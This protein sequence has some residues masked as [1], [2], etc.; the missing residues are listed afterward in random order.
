MNEKVAEDDCH[1]C[2]P[3][4]GTPARRTGPHTTKQ[5]QAAESKEHHG[6]TTK[7]WNDREGISL[8]GRGTPDR[9]VPARLV[10]AAHS[11]WDETRRCDDV[12]YFL[13]D[14]D[15][16]AHG[17]AFLLAHH[18]SRRAGKLASSLAAVDIGSGA[19][20]ALCPR[21]C[22]YDDRLDLCVR[23]WLVD[24]AVL[25]DPSTD[26]ADRRLAAG[27][28]D[29]ELARHHGMGAATGDQR[30]RGGR[31]GAYVH[32]PRPDHAAYAAGETDGRAD[33]EPEAGGRSDE[34]RP[35]IAGRLMI[36]VA[37]QDQKRSGLNSRPSARFPFSRHYLPHGARH[38]Q[39]PFERAP[40][41][42]S[43]CQSAEL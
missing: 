9:A 7:L 31:H 24:L 8:A 35:A 15:P 12:P 20:A 34:A 5:H 28:F 14:Y 11:S 16:C 13:W 30:P 33:Q 19:P 39:M 17:L 1:F 23:A 41:A 22:D 36:R 6:Q 18:P 2:K 43:Q 25:C 26:V 4:Y 21:L 38:P 3:G 40:D 29:R 32:F 42:T 27:T 10:Y 37:E